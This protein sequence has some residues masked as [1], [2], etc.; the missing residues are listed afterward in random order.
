MPEDAV[1]S[2][3]RHEQDEALAAAVVRALEW[4]AFVP[5]DHI[6]ATAFR[7]AVTLMGE[8]DWEYQRQDAERV[9][10]GVPG[11]RSVTNLLVV[12]ERDARARFERPTSRLPADP[13][14]PGIGASTTRSY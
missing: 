6:R 11:V 4:D 3:A 1:H 7:G 8:V 9:L 10:R 5:I 14:R 2:T 12:R 13:N